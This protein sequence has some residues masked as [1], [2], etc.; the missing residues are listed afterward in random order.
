M[1]WLLEQVLVIVLACLYT[2]LVGYC[3]HR[4]LHGGRV[5]WMTRKHMVHH[6]DFYGPAMKMRTPTYRDRETRGGVAGVGWEWLA[7]SL[8]LVIVEL[9][10][11]QVAGIGAV[12]QVVFFVGGSAWSVLMFYGAH[13][14]MH[15]SRASRFL[16]W[17]LRRWF[18]HGRRLHA[19]H[20]V[21]IDDAGKFQGNFGIL[22]HGFDR[23]F[24]TYLRKVP[25]RASPP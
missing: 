8:M 15:V 16:A 14:A 21:A 24:G 25:K 20:H 13:E 6:L 22:F 3:L 19:I 23:L 10:V 18:L 4:F 12:A 2:E 9:V 11:L 5:A 17:P 1:R 7:P